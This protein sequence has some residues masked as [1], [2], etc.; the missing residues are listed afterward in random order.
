MCQCDG[1]QGVVLAVP[2]FLGVLTVQFRF[3]DFGLFDR[4]KSVNWRPFGIAQKVMSYVLKLKQMVKF[5]LCRQE[6]VSIITF[7]RM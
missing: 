6:M 3:R 5:L 7:C 4:M 2:A 1:K